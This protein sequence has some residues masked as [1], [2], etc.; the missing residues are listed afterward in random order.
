ME[1][2]NSPPKKPKTQIDGIRSHLATAT[3][4]EHKEMNKALHANE[5]EGVPYYPPSWQARGGRVKT[6]NLPF[7]GAFRMIT[8]SGQGLLAKDLALQDQKMR[9]LWRLCQNHDIIFIQET[10]STP[11]AAAAWQHTLEFRPFYSHGDAATA[12]VIILIRES[13]LRDFNPIA[14]DCI[15]KIE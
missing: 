9:Q 2:A 5:D 1:I 13:F 11:G 3:S 12:G 6:R 8:W 10:H 14:K 7:Q 4:P 15:A